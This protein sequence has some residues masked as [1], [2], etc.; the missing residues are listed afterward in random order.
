MVR[1]IIRTK[2]KTLKEKVMAVTRKCLELSEDYDSFGWDFSKYNGHEIRF[3][4]WH[5]DTD[6]DGN[7]VKDGFFFPLHG[8]PLVDKYPEIMR[9]LDELKWS[10]LVFEQE[11][12]NG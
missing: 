11:G 6:E 5:A 9:E 1:I 3:T 10:A 7:V 4:A 8:V 2:G 12:D